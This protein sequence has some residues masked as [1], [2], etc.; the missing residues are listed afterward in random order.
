MY[1]FAYGANLS[2]KQMLELC[3]DAKPRFGATLP[4]YQLIFTGRGSRKAPGG[5]ASIKRIKGE[6]VMGGIYEIT[7]RCL[8]ALDQQ[9][10]YPSLY[11]RANVVVFT[12]LD[13]PV[14]AI[15]H[16]K[17]EQSEETAPSKEYLSIIRQGYQEWGLI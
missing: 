14:E 15:T 6:K 3:P 2:R 12:G 9:K 16:V 8:R 13:E 10:G 5:Q 11:N 1:Y 4:G 17:V 7:E